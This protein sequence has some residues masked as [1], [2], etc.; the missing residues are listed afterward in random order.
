M[1][2]TSFQRVVLLTLILSINISCSA[3]EF[4]NAIPFVKHFQPGKGKVKLTSVSIHTDTPELNSEAEVLKEIFSEHGISQGGNFPICLEIADVNFPAIDSDYQD[5][6]ESQGYLL[7]IT[8]QQIAISGR[9]G[10]GVFY[11][12]QT[13]RQLIDSKSQVQ[14]GQ[15]SDWPDMPVRMVM[16]DSARQNENIDYYKR[17]IKFFGQY[18][19]NGLHLHLTDD[20]FS[21]LYHEDYPWIMHPKAMRREDIHALVTYGKKY[22]VDIMPE[23]E[24][25]GH[26]GMFERHPLMRE[27]LHQAPLDAKWH[28]IKT[29][30]H[31]PGFS[32]VL[33][34]ASDLTYEYLDKMYARCA[35]LFPLTIIHV[36]LD[37]VKMEGC[38]RCAK[39]FPGISKKDWVLKHIERCVE[40]AKKYDRKIAIWNDMPW[41]YGDE[42]EKEFV[43]EIS[44]KDFVIMD[45]HYNKAAERHRKIYKQKGFDVIGCPAL[46]C[47]P[48][49]LI[50]DPKRFENIQEFATVARENDLMG[51]DTTLW[52][53]QYYMSDVLLTGLAFSGV[54]CWAGSN[55]D[56]TA[57]YE[58]FFNDFFGSTSGSDFEQV[59]KDLSNINWGSRM[60]WLSCWFGSQNTAHENIYRNDWL[61]NK[62]KFE[63]TRE[64]A[65]RRQKE[66]REKIRK[67]NE[68]R[69]RLKEVGS[70]VTENKIAWQ[71][72]ERSAAILQ[73]SMEHFLASTEVYSDGKWDKEKVEALDKDCL[74]VIGWLE[75]DWDRNR[76]ADDLGKDGIV[77]G[78][79]GHVFYWFKQTHKVHQRI[80][81]SK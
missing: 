6:I 66:V 62:K 58:R 29:N 12:I 73:Y 76:F 56:E 26:S 19:I 37:E 55:W 11:G 9:T 31:V 25:L 71:V 53:P 24:S 40:L 17:L 41:R 47:L 75:E 34:P 59:W 3:A 65:V 5:R 68:I 15:I 4:D 39:K 18:K 44:P 48:S 72:I 14:T 67:L 63:V 81:E 27:I 77:L 43:E 50:Q 70:S 36:G 35:E 64:N 16:L 7:K 13:L 1:I 42:A 74:K 32:P 22:H 45:W 80:L 38:D 28:P 57:F 61:F 78:S 69:N 33:C 8:D 46:S 21:A 51:I 79:W 49:M 23:I 10:A 54:Q 20:Q 60:I 52:C 30:I 2:R